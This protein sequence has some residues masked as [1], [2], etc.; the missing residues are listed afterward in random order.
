MEMDSGK[1]E[2]SNKIERYGVRYKLLLVLIIAGILLSL[3]AKS[4]AGWLIYGKPEFKGKVI[5]AETKEPIEGAVIVAVY[6]KKAIRIA[7]ESVSITIDV[8]ETLTN[9]EGNFLIPSYTTIID[10]FAWSKEVNFIIFKPGYGSFPDWRIRPPRGMGMEITFEKF[11]SGEVG[12]EKEVW[13]TTDPWKIGAESKKEKVAFGVVE[14]PKLKTRDERR[15]AS[16][17]GVTGYRSK[18]LPLLY[19]TLNEEQRYLGMPESE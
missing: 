15:K 12:V 5:D 19:K 1:S 3:A 14:L 9:K 8:K 6:S 18:D 4:Q 2:N 10:P 13:V 11:F 17:V 7:P 16:R